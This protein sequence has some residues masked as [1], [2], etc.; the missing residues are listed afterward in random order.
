MRLRAQDPVATGSGDSVSYAWDLLVLP[1]GAISRPSPVTENGVTPPALVL[2]LDPVTGRW[3]GGYTPENGRRRVF[4]GAVGS[5]QT[6]PLERSRGWI[7]LAGEVPVLRVG[8]WKL[9]VR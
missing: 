6:S 4:T 2:R 7:E 3:T 1:N 9:D 5:A 8:T